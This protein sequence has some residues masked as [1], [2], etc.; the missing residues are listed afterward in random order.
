MRKIIPAGTAALALSLLLTGCGGGSGWD[1][2]ELSADPS[3]G[4]EIGRAHV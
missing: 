4:T 3:E 1:S 2:V